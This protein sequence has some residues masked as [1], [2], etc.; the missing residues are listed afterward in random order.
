VPV[1]G[2]F[3]VLPGVVAGGAGVVVLPVS[4]L[5][6]G[7]GVVVLPVSGFVAGGGF[8]AEPV[9]DLLVSVF[10]VDGDVD[11]TSDNFGPLGSTLV[12]EHDATRKSTTR[13]RTGLRPMR[14][15]LIKRRTG[16]IDGIDN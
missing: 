13:Y 8:D 4:G 10:V 2:G 16:V 7:G 11:D 5:V 1:D 9:D 12:L 15:R 3:V 14:L 6:A